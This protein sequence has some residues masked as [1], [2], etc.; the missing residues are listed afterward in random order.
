MA[1]KLNPVLVLN[2]EVTKISNFLL[3]DALDPVTLLFDSFALI[4]AVLQVV[5]ASL[6]VEFLVL[7]DLKLQG[8]FVS[9]EGFLLLS[10]QLTLP[11]FIQ[12]LLLDNTA[13]LST[14]AI[15]LLG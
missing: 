13:E 2:L 8:L 10:L 6:L 14:A 7:A 4:L 5:E 11:L 9:L 3:L 1:L 15:C 12:L